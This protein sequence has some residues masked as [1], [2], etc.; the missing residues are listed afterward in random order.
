MSEVFIP[1][2]ARLEY[3]VIGASQ[4]WRIT[5]QRGPMSR[6]K[7]GVIGA[8]MIAQIEHIPN[9]LRLK[10]KFE[11]VGVS[12]P[13]RASREFVSDVLGV[14]AYEKAEDLYGHDLAAVLI[15]SPDPLHYEQVL[16][17]LKTRLHVFCEK[18]L[19]YSPAEI[20]E[21]I[22]ARNTA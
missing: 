18:P 17:A 5:A 3:L 2:L 4:L 22:A 12:D 9:L 7:I 14:P 16:Q 1:N 19:C 15:A 21:I 6:V 11:L 13:S 8:G 20:D 10:D